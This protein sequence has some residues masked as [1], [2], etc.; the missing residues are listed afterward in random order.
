LSSETLLLLSLSL[1]FVVLPEVVFPSDEVAREELGRSELFAGEL[2]AVR[3]DCLSIKTEATVDE[4]GDV[5]GASDTGKGTAAMAGIR[6]FRALLEPD[7]EVEDFA[8][9][10]G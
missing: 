3:R 1:R 8:G 7:A 6:L 10:A 5:C 9:V 4:V 2:L